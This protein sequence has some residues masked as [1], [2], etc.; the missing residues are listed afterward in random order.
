MQLFF[1]HD[2]THRPGRPFLGLKLELGR[3]WQVGFV[4]FSSPVYFTSLINNNAWRYTECVFTSTTVY[5]LCKFKAPAWLCWRHFTKIRHLFSIQRDSLR[6]RNVDFDKICKNFV[7]YIYGTSIHLL[8]GSV[9]FTSNMNMKTVLT[10]IKHGFLFK[11]I[12]TIEK[13]FGQTI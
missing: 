5:S 7:Y 12:C 2:E 6:Y 10:S 8:C 3:V 9:S 4:Q 1:S 13:D 11:W